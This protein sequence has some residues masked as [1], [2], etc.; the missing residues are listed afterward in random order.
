MKHPVTCAIPFEQWP[1]YYASCNSISRV[2]HHSEHSNTW[3]PLHSHLIGWDETRRTGTLSHDIRHRYTRICFRR[4]RSFVIH[5]ISSCI[6]A[7]ML[8]PYYTYFF[9][10]KQNDLFMGSS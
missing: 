2:I 9:H 1:T 10:D 8:R 4:R 5:V 6:L 3:R 7:R